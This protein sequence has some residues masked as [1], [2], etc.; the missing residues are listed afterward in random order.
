MPEIEDK[1]P[2]PERRPYVLHRV[3]ERFTAGRQQYRIE[4]SLHRQTRLQFFAGK[5]H[6]R[7]RIEADR[8]DTAFRRIPLVEEP[9]AARKADHRHLG[10]MLPQRARDPACRFDDPA[11]KPVLRKHSGPT[12]EQLDDVRTGG[13]LHREIGTCRLSQDIDERLKPLG[14]AIGP[15]LDPEKIPAAAALDHIGRDRP[16]TPGKADQRGLFRQSSPTSPDRLADR[17][18]P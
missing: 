3:L 10:K 16:R 15:A 13:D 4:I 11:C 8:R 2:A 5:I 12:V 7:R 14:I 6:R 1:W 17:F 9:G 18:E